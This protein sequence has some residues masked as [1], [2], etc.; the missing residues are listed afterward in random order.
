M[1]KIMMKR[2]LRLTQQRADKTSGVTTISLPTR[3]Q[4]TYRQRI[5]QKTRRNSETPT[6]NPKLV[7]A[8]SHTIRLGPV[9]R[10][11]A[12][13]C[14]GIREC[15]L[16]RTDLR[17]VL[18]DLACQLFL[19]AWN[20]AQSRRFPQLPFPPTMLPPRFRPPTLHLH[21]QSNQI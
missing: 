2:E 12:Q 21:R 5:L 11:S 13:R 9:G 3:M 7:L 14:S 16:V 1:L 17:V 6:G 15:C 10:H 19:P 18:W 20:Q 4:N 8:H